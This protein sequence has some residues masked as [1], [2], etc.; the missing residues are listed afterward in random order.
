MVLHHASEWRALFDLHAWGLPAFV[1]ALLL[2]VPVH[3]FIHAVT[4][5]CGLRSP[6]L[7]LG[8]W[9]QRGLVYVLCDAP[10]PRRR[11][12]FM[13]AA[14]FA[15]LTILPLGL[16]VFLPADVRSLVGFFLVAHVGAC[17][18]DAI[19]FARLWSQVPAHALIHNQGGTTY[20][21]TAFSATAA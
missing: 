18:G 11:V 4:Y 20:W 9:P 13:L 5:G 10:L 7:M 3:E 19:T 15:L 21:G 1:I 17:A 16:L 14:P 6:N 8:A 2:V 12:L